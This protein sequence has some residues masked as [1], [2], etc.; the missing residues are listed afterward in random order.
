VAIYDNDILTDKSMKLLENKTYWKGAVYRQAG[1]INFPMEFINSAIVIMINRDLRL[2]TIR[3]FMSRG[4]EVYGILEDLDLWNITYNYLYTN[5]FEM[6]QPVLS[7]IKLETDY[8][9]ATMIDVFEEQR[10]FMC[11]GA[12]T[13]AYEKCQP[14][15]KI[16]VLKDNDLVVGICKIEINE[17]ENSFGI[18]NF[19]IDKK[20]QGKGYGK[21]MLKQVL[22][23]LRKTSIKEIRIGVDRNNKIA[24]KTYLACGFEVTSTS[25]WGYMLNYSFKK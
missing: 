14:Q 25:A 13:L 23:I 22:E 2:M 17:K 24:Y 9:M 4:I 18:Y 21:E 3:Y 19:T 7:K 20:F 11:C 10:R 12:V 1:F 6:N 5:Y 8:D 16:Y 15:E